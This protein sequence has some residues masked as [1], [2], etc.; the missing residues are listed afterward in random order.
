[1]FIS[2]CNRWFAGTDKIHESGFHLL[3]LV[4]F[5]L[6]STKGLK[7][8]EER[9]KEDKSKKMETDNRALQGFL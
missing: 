2:L 1:M 4:L 5:L 6:L 9:N 7:K 3:A 8:G